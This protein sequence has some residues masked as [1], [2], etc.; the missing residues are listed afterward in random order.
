MKK[1]EVI[2]N[3]VDERVEKPLVSA[4]FGDN[5]RQHQKKMLDEGQIDAEMLINLAWKQG[6]RALLLEDEIRKLV[7]DN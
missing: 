6:R 1:S 7:D 2:I 3:R 5:W 4:K